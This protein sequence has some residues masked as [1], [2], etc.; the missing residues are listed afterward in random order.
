MN[1]HA[2]DGLRADE[3][4][5]LPLLAPS[6]GVDTSKAAAQSVSP[7]AARTLRRKVYELIHTAGHH[8]LTADEIE[9]LT[10]KPSHSITPRLWELVKLGLIVA[11]VVKRDTRAG[12]PAH[13]YEVTGAP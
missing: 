3:L 5:E 8:G 13:V 9:V 4:L 11:T 6:Q 1:R 7:G 12:R 10:G 2:T